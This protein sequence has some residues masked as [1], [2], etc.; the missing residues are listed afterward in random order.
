MKF[1]VTVGK[2][3][4]S[5][6]PI[7]AKKWADSLQVPYVPR[8][9]K[10]TLKGLLHDN[11][12]DCLLVATKKGP[13][14]V[15]EDDTLFYHPSMAVLRID[16]LL[17]GQEDNFV[18]ACNLKPGTRFLDCT[19]GFASDS[20]IASFVVGDTGKVVGLEASK[21]IWFIVKE[22][23]YT[24]KDKR[25]ELNRAMRKIEVIHEEAF[26]YLKTLKDNSFDVVYF[27]P[28]FKHPVKDSSNMHPL[29][30][31]SFAK[32]LTKEIVKE[33]LR[34]APL[35]VVKERTLSVFNSLGI[36]ELTGGK[37]SKIK[38]GILRR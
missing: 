6:L 19:L 9:E 15:T 29:R 38:Y 26:A 10:G 32:P 3:E 4:D 8:P 18:K 37:Y 21:P 12:L 35:V 5:S 33:A 23:L 14:I 34:V 27:D 22:G 20:A 24:Y 13:Q 28:M 30:K 31:V 17:Q 36:T 2:N 1:A 7:W 16:K 11:G 25:E